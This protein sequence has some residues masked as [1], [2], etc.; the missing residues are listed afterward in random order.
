MFEAAR[1]HFFVVGADRSGT[2]L[3]RLMLNEHPT[4]SVGPE[5]WFFLDLRRRFSVQQRLNPAEVDEALRIIV[6]HERYPHLGV[7]PADL[8]SR[9]ETLAE[10]T[11]GDLFAL[12]GAMVAEREGAA[13]YGDKTPGYSHCI[14][15]LAEAYP[16]AK[17][18]HI[19]RDARDV[20]LSLMRVGWYG[21]TPWRA[22]EH[23][24]DRVGACEQARAQLGSQ[25]MIRLDY[26]DLV[27]QTDATLRR[28]CEFLEVAFDERMLS[29]YETSAEHIPASKAAHHR[30]TTRPP[31]PQ[32]VDLWKRD[33]DRRLLRYVEGGA[34]RLMR[35]VGQRPSLRGLSGL[36]AKAS[37]GAA[38]LRMRLLYP[39][40]LRLLRAGGRGGVNSAPRPARADNL[41]GGER[42]GRG[43]KQGASLTDEDSGST[44]RPKD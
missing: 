27:L 20:A 18:V 17:F 29:F 30:K 14:L 43:G 19:V 34:A 25:R 28:L 24:I 3:L 33:A 36:L 8:R 1:P 12:P 44:L 4:L 39:L 26:A 37:W 35:Q 21:G 15:D 42:S 5:T 38:L 9:A 23:W 13:H 22:T 40:R 31:S 32:D 7:A 2:T 16:E 11:I 10:P 6:S 41:P